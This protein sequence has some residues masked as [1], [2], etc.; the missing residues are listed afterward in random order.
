[1]I[2]NMY[3]TIQIHKFQFPVEYFSLKFR[4]NWVLGLFIYNWEFIAQNWKSGWDEKVS[5]QKIPEQKLEIWRKL[6]N[7][8][9]SGSDGASWL[10]Q[11]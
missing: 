3:H 7:T 9:F 6:E 11:M 4:Q 1:M 5:W 8:Y 2:F 10:I